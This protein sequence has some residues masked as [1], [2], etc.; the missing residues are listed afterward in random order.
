[1]FFFSIACDHGNDLNEVEF[2]Y[3]AD[4]VTHG[5]GYKIVGTQHISELIETEVGSINKTSNL[6]R[7]NW[8][9]L[10]INPPQ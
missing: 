10:H 9:T 7:R 6:M 5:N 1:M 4:V 8:G 3:N 2:I